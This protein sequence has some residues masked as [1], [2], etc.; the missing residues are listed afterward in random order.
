LAAPLEA[1]VKAGEKLAELEALTKAAA[2]APVT[3]VD[4]QTLAEMPGFMP[5]DDFEGAKPGFSF[6][7]GAQVSRHG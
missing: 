2:A 4:L 7:T 1:V 3:E 6:K 5:A